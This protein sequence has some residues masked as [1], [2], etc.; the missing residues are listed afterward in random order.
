MPKRRALVEELVG[1]AKPGVLEDR[2]DDVIGVA[3]A[4]T[5]EISLLGKGAFERSDYRGKLGEPARPVGA[6]SL[7]GA[8]ERRL[9]RA[10]VIGAVAGIEA[11][12]EIGRDQ[13]ADRGAQRV[14][15]PM[16]NQAREATPAGPGEQRGAVRKKVLEIAGDV[17]GI[18]DDP[19]AIGDDRDKMLPAQPADRLDI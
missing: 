16:V 13:P 7:Q 3:G 12:D 8:A 6:I 18:V 14:V 5:C 19:V 4:R 9:A 1:A 10:A 17:P 15:R 2:E 11:A